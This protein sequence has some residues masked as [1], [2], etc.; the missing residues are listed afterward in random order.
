VGEEGVFG[1]PFGLL[2]SEDDAIRGGDADRRCAA[3]AELLDGFPDGFDA[4]ASQLDQFERQARLVDQRESATFIAGPAHGFRLLGH[5]T[6][7]T[8]G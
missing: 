5:R 2:Q 4:R 6:I 7:C 8:G 1:V 3:D